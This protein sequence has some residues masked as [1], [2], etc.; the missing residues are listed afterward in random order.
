[1]TEPEQKH[2]VWVQPKLGQKES[3]TARC[4]CGWIGED[5]YSPEDADK[6]AQMHMRGEYHPW[7]IPPGEN[8]EWTPNT[9]MDGA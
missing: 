7:I 1:M 4:I 3:F 8:R 6:D 9:R 5:E 2:K